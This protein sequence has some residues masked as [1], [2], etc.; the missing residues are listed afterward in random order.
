MFRLAILFVVAIVCFTCGSGEAQSPP[1][2]AA[3]DLQLTERGRVPYSA[4]LTFADGP[5]AGTY[6][7][8]QTKENRGSITAKAP[9]KDF[10]EDR[11]QFAGMSS[12]TMRSMTT[13]D[14]SFGIRVLSRWLNGELRV[15]QLTS[16]KSE[17][18]S[19]RGDVCGSMEL[20]TDDPEGTIRHVFVAFL[21]CGPL[22]I[23][24]F[25]DEWS[26]SKY[27]FTRKR[28]MAGS[29]SERVRITDT[30]T[31]A[32]TKETHETTMTI[33]FIGAHTEETK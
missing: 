5:F 28:V 29:F 15:G 33:T 27:S 11:P 9:T 13:A 16:H 30:N 25:G 24:G 12:F 4:V 18:P 23:T 8:V 31:T 2:P 7:L 20:M 26:K 32:G 22:Q 21:D 6:E 10:L 19:T 17:T 3:S 14:G 1:A